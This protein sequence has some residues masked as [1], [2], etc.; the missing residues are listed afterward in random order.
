MFSIA[1]ARMPTATE[2]MEDKR[3]SPPPPLAAR[4][5]LSLAQVRPPFHK[6][7]CAPRSSL[8][9]F[10]KSL[11]WSGF[12][13]LSSKNTSTTMGRTQAMVA[14]ARIGREN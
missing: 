4:S 12:T 1:M 7:L 6:K 9:L 8:Y 13:V 14:G 3:A 5:G 11:R 2:A 10:P